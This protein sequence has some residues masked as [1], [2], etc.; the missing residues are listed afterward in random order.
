MKR[1]YACII[2]M[3]TIIILATGSLFILKRNNDLLFAQLDR[4]SQ[5]YENNSQTEKE[6]ALLGDMW[7]KYYLKISYISKTDYLNDIS[8]NVGRL[9]FLLENQSDEFTSE[10]EN[11]RTKATLLYKNQFP[12][13][14]SLL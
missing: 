5:A 6:L 7:E 10:L 1:L 13:L 4:V 3:C 8:A 11:I 9:N 2:I 14:Y 12:Y